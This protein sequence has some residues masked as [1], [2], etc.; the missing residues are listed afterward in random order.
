MQTDRIIITT[1]LKKDTLIY[2]KLLQVYFPLEAKGSPDRE[3]NSSATEEATFIPS[4]QKHPTA[5][6]KG[7][8]HFTY[9]YNFYF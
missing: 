1:F 6:G 3:E 9:L 5:P 4:L 2:E 7:L 8:M